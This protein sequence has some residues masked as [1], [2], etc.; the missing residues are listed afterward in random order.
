MFNAKLLRVISAYF[1]LKVARR[2]PDNNVD[3]GDR[4][5]IFSLGAEEHNFAGSSLIAK[6]T[7]VDACL[8]RKSRPKAFS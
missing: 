1:I 5:N 8:M 6:F 2:F 4:S 3:H 7:V